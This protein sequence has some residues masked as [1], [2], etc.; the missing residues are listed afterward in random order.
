VSVNS[1]SD[2]TVTLPAVTAAD[3]GATITVLKLGA[4]KV[5]IAANGTA[6]A[7]SAAGG[8]IYNNAFSPAYAA[9]TIRL[10]DAAHWAILSGEGAWLTTAP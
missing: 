4:G 5:T 7:D 6:I 10:A 1:A 2:V 8:T 9:L 3:I